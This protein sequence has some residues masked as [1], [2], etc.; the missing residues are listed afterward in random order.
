[1]K[2]I[3]ARDPG[4]QSSFPHSPGALDHF[5]HPGPCLPPTLMRGRTLTAVTHWIPGALPTPGPLKEA[6]EAGT[7]EYHDSRQTAP[8]T[9]M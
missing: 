3:G 2:N 9:G 1:M 7:W 8:Q 6:E 4:D 5:L